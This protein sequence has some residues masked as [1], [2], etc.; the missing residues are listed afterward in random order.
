MDQGAFLKEIAGQFCQFAPFTFLQGDVGE[1]ILAFHTADEIGQS[2]GPFIQVRMIDL[3]NI[4]SENNF[5]SF[6]SPSYDSFY[7]VGCQVLGFIYDKECLLQA[8]AAKVGKGSN[9]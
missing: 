6:A 4:P 5:C 1:N 3:M 9:K 2:V 7:F 8:T